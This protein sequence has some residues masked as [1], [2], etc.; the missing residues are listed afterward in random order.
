MKQGEDRPGSS[1]LKAQGTTGS[2]A[3]AEGRKGRPVQLG[4]LGH[5]VP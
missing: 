2:V 3:Q 4:K 5:K 1:K